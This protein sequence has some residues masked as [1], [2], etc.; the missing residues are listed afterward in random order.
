M[1]HAAKLAA[2]RIWGLK[3]KLRKLARGKGEAK[4]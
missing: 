4:A 3:I 1:Y 2:M